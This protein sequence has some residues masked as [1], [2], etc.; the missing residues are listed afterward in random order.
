MV[1]L[2]ESSTQLTAIRVSDVKPCSCNC[3]CWVVKVHL[4]KLYNVCTYFTCTWPLYKQSLLVK[5]YDDVFLHVTSK[6]RIIPKDVKFTQIT[7]NDQLH[8]TYH[9]YRLEQSVLIEV[10]QADSRIL[11]MGRPTSETCPKDLCSIVCIGLF[12]GVI[13]TA[14]VIW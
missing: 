3:E 7:I 4:L 10:D 2:N 9:H 1:L 11:E 6:V 8:H 14:V 12:A 13:I 5:L